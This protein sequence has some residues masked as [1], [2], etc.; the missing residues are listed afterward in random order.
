MNRLSRALGEIYE[1][2]DLA[3]RNLWI[4]RLHP[5]PKLAL[6][7]LYIAALT[8]TSVYD[9]GGVLR[10]GLYLPLVFKLSCLSFTQ[11]FRRL[12]FALPLVC[13]IGLA[14][15][16]LDVNR[17][18]LGGTSFSA[19]WLSLL[20]L[21]C[22]GVF[23]VL[24]SYQLVA[25]TGMD[26]ICA[27][28]RKLRVPKILV[29]QLLLTYRYIF[30]LLAQVETIAQAY[31]L[32]APRQNGIHIKVWGSLAGQ[33]LLRSVD[34]ATALY[35]SMRLR[36]FNGEYYYAGTGAD[37][38]RRDAAYFIVMLALILLLRLPPI[39]AIANYFTGGIS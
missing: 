39:T 23:S 26:R 18:A 17:I 1:L 35:D 5:L 20:T 21:A 37:L 30:L 14:N 36:G 15:P 38:S 24:A 28:L 13:C 31:S 11:A 3:R 27:A 7:L 32:R 25:S 6:T 10:L 12:R 33:L 9:V 4:N 29:T 22:K 8:N 19:G 16:L 2:E 34:R